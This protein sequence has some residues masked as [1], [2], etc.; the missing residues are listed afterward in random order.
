MARSCNR[1]GVHC[2]PHRVIF[3]T[4][5]GLPQFPTARLT[6]PYCFVPQNGVETRTES[7]YVAIVISP[8]QTLAILDSLASLL[9]R[10]LVLT[11]VL[12]LT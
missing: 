11:C 3:Q 5:R 9:H 6:S 12:S 1:R 10:I 7:D 4:V 2:T 8:Q